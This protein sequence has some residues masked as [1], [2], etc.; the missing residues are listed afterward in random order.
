MNKSIWHGCIIM[1]TH[2]PWSISIGVCSYFLF[3][4][5][6]WLL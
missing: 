3:W 6:V 5:S 1:Y 2:F 4:E